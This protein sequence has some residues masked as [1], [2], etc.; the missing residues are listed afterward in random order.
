MKNR[1][2][3]L[4]VVS[5]KVADLTPEEREERAWL[6]AQVLIDIHRKRLETE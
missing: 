6:V 1:D 2:V 5:E 3:E 4:H